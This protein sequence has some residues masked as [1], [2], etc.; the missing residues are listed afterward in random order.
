[1]R[2]AL[3]LEYPIDQLGGVEVLV[4]ELIL[5]LGP[6]HQIILVS[7]DDAASLARSRVAPLVSEHISFAP[8]WNSVAA[9]R[10]LAD[11][12]AQSRPDIVHFHG[13]NYCWGNRFPFHSPTPHLNRRGIPCVTTSHLVAGMFEGYCGANKPFWFKLLTFPLGWCG[14]MQQVRH[15]QCEIAVAK[16]DLKKLQSWYRPLR[17]RFRHIY[18]S[19]LRNQPLEPEGQKRQPVILNVGHVAQR[20]GQHILAEAFALV[21]LR[22]PEWTL[23]L[24]GPDQDHVTAEKIRKLMRERQLE[25]RIQLLGKR[26]NAPELMRQAVIYVQP[27]FVEGLPLSLQEAMFHGC[28]VVASRIAAH[29][30]LI[31]ENQTGLLFEAGNIPQLA[32]VLEQLMA[33]RQQCEILGRRAARSIRERKM[34]VEGMLEQHLELYRSVLGQSEKS[35]SSEP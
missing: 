18:H 13:G 26:D 33:S 11:K 17:G 4:T 12:I 20:K 27:S 2:I 10:G 29:E 16:N 31:F 3:C 9:A 34:T 21:A 1:M 23:Q 15:V 35:V 24:A 30:E 19:R 32:S 7:P 8:G 22:F 14:K 6:R 25:G 28:A 5:G